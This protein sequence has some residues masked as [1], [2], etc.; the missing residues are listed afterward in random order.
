MTGIANPVCLTDPRPHARLQ[1]LC[2]ASLLAVE[3]YYQAPL[4][5]P[6]PSIS[7]AIRCLFQIWS[8]YYSSP[9]SKKNVPSSLPALKVPAGDIGKEKSINLQNANKQ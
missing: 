4:P 6:I 1:P 9:H 5:P 7:A 3:T 2:S 8:I